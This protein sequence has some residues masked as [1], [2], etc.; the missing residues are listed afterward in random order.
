MKYLHNLIKQNK[1]ILVY[2]IFLFSLILFFMKGAFVVDIYVD[3]F[4]FFKISKANSIGDFMNFFSPIR[5]Y[6]YRP[7]PTE[8]F[9]FIINIL[10]KNLFI[11]HLISFFTYFIG[12]IFL[13][14]ITR[15][16]SCSQLFAFI[17]TFIYGISFTHVFQLYQLNTFQEICLMTFLSVSFYFFLKKKYFISLIFYLFALMSKETA[18]LFPIVLGAYQVLKFRHFDKRFSIAFLAFL[19]LSGA[20]IVLYYVSSLNVVDLENYELIFSPK[21]IFNNTIWYLLWGLGLPNFIPNYIESI[22]FKPLPEFWN[23][24]T[25][26]LVKTYFYAL[27]TFYAFLIPLFIVTLFRQKKS[28]IK[29]FEIIVFM[30]FLFLLFLA[31]TIPTIHRWMVRLTVPQVFLSI[32]ISLPIY[33]GLQEKNYLRFVSIMVLALYLIMN[34]IGI[35]LHESSG[36]F[37]LNSQTV[38]NARNYFQ[39]NESSINK[40]EIIY[41]VDS[42]RKNSG[43]SEE[44]KNILGTD[45]FVDTFFPDKQFKIIYGHDQKYIPEHSFVIYSNDI[46]KW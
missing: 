12:L 19:V 9:Y 42:S 8:L 27:I 35:Q 25:S 29:N 44:L 4:F 14:K 41:F 37:E 33:L 23:L 20:F 46:L 16:I 39:E 15:Y 26:A 17:F 6:F 45:Y 24:M 11:A 32:T 7:I 28:R 22:L 38:R 40:Y 3:D 30:L 36:L 5:N 2:F 31:P 18:I 21:L 10:N 13:Y 1:Y 43:G 34:I